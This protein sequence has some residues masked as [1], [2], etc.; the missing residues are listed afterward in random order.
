MNP[1]CF[2]KLRNILA[3]DSHNTGATI[4]IVD[5]EPLNVDLLEQ[6]LADAGYCTLSAT[7][8]HQALKLAAT[9]APDLI[10]LD[11]MMEGMDGYEVCEQLKAGEATRAIP[12]IFLTALTDTFEKVRAFSTGAV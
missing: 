7:S 6:E 9:T 2:R 8:G 4:L 12:V 10:L 1:C 11:V 5:D 3:A